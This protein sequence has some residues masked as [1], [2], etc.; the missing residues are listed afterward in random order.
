M[1]VR[2]LVL[3]FAAA[4]LLAGGVSAAR[5]HTVWLEPGDG[6]EFLVR[7]GGHAG[8]LENYSPDKLIEVRAVA[9]DGAALA[10][11]RTDGAEGVRLRVRGEPALMA[12]HFDN[13]YWSKTADGASVNRPMTEVEQASSGVRAVKYHKSILAW[14]ELAARPLGQPFE[15][16]PVS[17]ERPRPG[18]PLTLRV[19]V[20]GRPAPGIALAFDEEGRETVSDAQ[21]LA[22]LVVKPG[23]N[24]I[25]AGQRIAL[26]DDP[27]ATQ[28]ST[29]Y[30]LVFDAGPKLSLAAS[31]LIWI[32]TFAAVSGL[33]PSLRALRRRKRAS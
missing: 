10:M 4:L 3:T 32:G 14:G 2:P 20:D 13:G 6:A 23:V 21:G 25:W 7:F 28:H 5:A 8:V 15:L 16:V 31:A 18:Q 22:S 30:T 27:R 26:T 29:E 17:G 9:A 11:D 19:L 33:P 12:L 1:P 24:R